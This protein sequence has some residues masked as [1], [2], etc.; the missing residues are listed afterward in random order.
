MEDIFLL[1]KFLVG[2]FN[3]ILFCVDPHA[4]F[5][6]LLSALLFDLKYTIFYYTICYMDL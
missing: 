4:Y 3:D 6:C 5:I 2:V 1:S